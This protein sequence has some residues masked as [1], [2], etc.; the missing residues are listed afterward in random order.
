MRQAYF[1]VKV[2]SPFAR[3]NANLSTAQLYKNAERYKIREYKERIRTVEHGDFTPLVFTCSGGMVP[4][5][6]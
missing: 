4:Q 2:V 6:H 5:S 3:S 1:D